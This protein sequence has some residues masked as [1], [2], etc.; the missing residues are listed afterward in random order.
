MK[1]IDKKILHAIPKSPFQGKFLDLGWVLQAPFR[2][3][4]GYTTIFR[5]ISLLQK[6]GHRS[7][8]YIDPIAHLSPKKPEE[9][10]Q[11]IVQHFNADAQIQI[12]HK[13]IKKH[14]VLF[15]TAWSTASVVYKTKGSFRKI[16]FV[17]ATVSHFVFP[18]LVRA[19]G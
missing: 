8:V 13:K 17:G 14:D 16:Y 3:S 2:G 4:G 10:S 5:F 6:W 1:D 18:N 12:G 19:T 9:I 11:Y 7:T 15:A